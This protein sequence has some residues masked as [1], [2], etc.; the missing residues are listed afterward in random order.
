M[1]RQKRGKYVVPR[2]HQECD[3]V[4]RFKFLHNKKARQADQSGGDVQK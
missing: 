4:R 2:S 1:P 3:S